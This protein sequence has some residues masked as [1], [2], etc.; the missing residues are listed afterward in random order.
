MNLFHYISKGEKT[1]TTFIKATRVYKDKA[2]G[3]LKTQS[4]IIAK[5]EIAM[6][7]PS[8][9]LGFPEHRATITLASGTVVDVA[10]TFRELS[11]ALCVR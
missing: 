6:V 7:R 4:V 5:A 9:R 10:D 3:E 2:S 1:M 11:A 8:N